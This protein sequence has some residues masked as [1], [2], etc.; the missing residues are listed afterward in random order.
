MAMNE[1]EGKKPLFTFKQ[2]ALAWLVLLTMMTVGYGITFVIMLHTSKE[3]IE[4]QML[5]VTYV[6]RTDARL[7]ALEKKVAALEAQQKAPAQK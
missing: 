4:G 3:D 1:G 5:M 7:Q 6:Q 2:V